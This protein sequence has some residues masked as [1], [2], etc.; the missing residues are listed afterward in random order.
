MIIEVVTEKD[1]KKLKK[2]DSY[3]ITPKGLDRQIP[4]TF[5]EY[6]EEIKRLEDI[7]ADKF[8]TEKG[9]NDKKNK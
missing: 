9:K 7:I 1:I 3:I 4:E 2:G 5:I 8:S 6:Q